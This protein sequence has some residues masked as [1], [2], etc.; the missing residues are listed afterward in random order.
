MFSQ[1]DAIGSCFPPVLS[2]VSIFDHTHPPHLCFQIL[3]PSPT[4]A[5]GPLPHVEPITSNLA[6]QNLSQEHP[7]FSYMDS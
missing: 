2:L 7:K 3:L 5:P 1:E 4:L 6:L